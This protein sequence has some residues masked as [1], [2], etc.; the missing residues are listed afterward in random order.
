MGLKLS[1]TRG[2]NM[3]VASDDMVNIP[4]RII[5]HSRLRRGGDGETAGAEA[6]LRDLL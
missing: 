5:V 4:L 3:S 6:M 1:F 2:G